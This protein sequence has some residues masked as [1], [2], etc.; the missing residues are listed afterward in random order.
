MPTTRKPGLPDKLPRIGLALGGG[1]ARG[2]A[3]IAVLEAFEELGIAPSMIAGTSIGALYG[4]AYASGMSAAHIRALTEE[5]LGSRFDVIRQL[6][7]SRAPALQKLLSVIPMRSALLDPAALLDH[8]LPQQFAAQF[9]ALQIPLAVVA[10]DLAAH[11]A[12]V[13]REGDLRTA[14]AASIAIPVLFAPVHIEGRTFVDGGIVNP[15]PFDVIADE[16][17]IVV[18]IDVSGAAVD[19]EVGPSP[20]M[21]S[22]LT[23]SVQ[24]LQKTIIRE[25][26]RHVRPD[27]YIDVDL[28]QFG[29][30][31]FHK[32]AAPLKEELKVRLLRLLTSRAVDEV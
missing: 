9:D 20:S 16:V 1:G 3:H 26:L 27:L 24:I 22:V 7:S 4:A 19:V 18:A 31:Q 10:T 28:D 14:V 30:L 17:D 29:A 5:T 11:E 13:L 8:V 25:R 32:A 6:F 2:L 23:Q 12:V 21:V 15:L